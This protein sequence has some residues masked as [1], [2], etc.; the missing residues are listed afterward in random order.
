MLIVVIDFNQPSY[1][2]MENN[3]VTIAIALSQPSPAPFEVTIDT[4][5][6]SAHGKNLVGSYCTC[7]V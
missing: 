1:E 7:H 4:M 6:V 2:V 5:D 3:T